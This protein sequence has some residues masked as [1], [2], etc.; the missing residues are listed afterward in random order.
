MSFPSFIMPLPTGAHSSCAPPSPAEG[1]Q[2]GI[3]AGNTLVADRRRSS[4]GL[5]RPR[6]LLLVIAA[7]ALMTI[8]AT[9]WLEFYR[10]FLGTG[11]P[12][13]ELLEVPRGIGA[14]PVTL[15]FMIGNP[16]AGMRDVQLYGI[17][18]GERK[19]LLRQELFGKKSAEISF[20][21]NGE[22][23]DLAEGGAQI[24]IVGH[25]NS[26]WKTT[27]KREFSVRVDFRRPKVVLMSSQQTI[28]QGGTRLIF[29]KA[30]DEEL[31]FSG[32]K[33]GSVTFP[34]FPARGL[35]SEFDDPALFVAFYSVGLDQNPDLAQPRVFAEDAVGN[36][37]S[38]P[39]EGRVLRRSPRPVSLQLTDEFLRETVA[40]IIDVYLEKARRA[41]RAAGKNPNE[42]AAGIEGR[43]LPEKFVFVVQDLRTINSSEIDSAVRSPRFERIWD[44]AFEAARGQGKLL[45]GD[46]LSYV[47]GGKELLQTRQLG[48]E[49]E[50]PRDDREVRGGND[51]V[52]V[53][54]DTLGAYGPTVIVDHGLG[55]S[56]VYA[57]LESTSVRRGDRVQK[58]QRVGYGGRGWFSTSSRFYFEIRVQGRP[59]DPTEWMDGGWYYTQVVSEINEAKKSLGIPVYRPLS[60]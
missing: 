36:A 31:S 1:A 6:M 45:Y 30:F 42:V 22:K 40:P 60:R 24:E 29:Y 4:A 23:G 17:Q 49:I 28:R 27:V 37:A 39:V 8:A 57:Q 26:I 54:S 38:V 53:Y 51:G 34:G 25:D 59:V 43:T 2:S 41:A 55:I 18:G 48:I 15:R 12:G 13:I 47:Y 9:G 44:G 14:A 35:D 21:F 3:D 56:S 52:V 5:V 58:G 16:V 19:E 10:T 33:V 20:T 11:S 46:L 7:A 32:V 50:L